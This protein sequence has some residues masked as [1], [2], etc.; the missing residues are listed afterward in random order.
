M[1]DQPPLESA[2]L[3]P[4]LQVFANASPLWFK[5]FDQLARHIWLHLDEPLTVV[6]LAE[7]THLSVYHF[8]RMFGAAFGEPIGSYI[9]RARLIKAVGELLETDNSVTDIALGCGFSSSQA[10]AKALKKQTAMTPTQVRQTAAQQ[11]MQDL[12]RLHASLG[13]PVS[14]KI[15]LSQEQKM[16]E[17]LEFVTQEKPTRYFRCVNVESPS[18]ENVY[19]V[20]KKTTSDKSQPM[21]TI[22]FARNESM[23][24]ED[25][26]VWV[27][28]ECAEE[29]ATHTLLAGNYLATRI[30]VTST[31][32]YFSAWEALAN[33]IMH[34][35]QEFDSAAPMLEITHNPTAMFAP[36]DMTLT[37]RL[38]N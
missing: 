36:V 15:A 25:M 14:S 23:A 31:L 27:G 22:T 6:Q 9:R 38:I 20:W 10:F 1:S 26:D 4:E 29:E 35:G 28:D 24:F 5:R 21:V 33:H 8:H 37:A 32:G 7:I 16:A 19:R 18:M 11:G 3:S 34:T 13:R 12:M 17:E 2:I 30:S